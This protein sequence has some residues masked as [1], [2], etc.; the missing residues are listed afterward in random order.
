MHVPDYSSIFCTLSHY[1]FN[2]LT[3]IFTNFQLLALI[4][5]SNFYSPRSP[6][7]VFPILMVRPQAYEDPIHKLN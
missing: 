3:H 4:E 6:E 1:L 2:Q 5:I 7:V